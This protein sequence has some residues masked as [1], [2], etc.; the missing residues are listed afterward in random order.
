MDAWEREVVELHEVFEAYFLGTMAN[1]LSRVE[2][3][4]APEFSM[5]APSGDEV[6]RT[7]IMEYLQ[8]AYGTL[9]QF[10]IW[11]ED[12]RVQFQSDELVLASYIEAQSSSDGETRRRSSVMF[13]R[14]AGGPNGLRWLR[15][16]ETWLA[17]SEVTS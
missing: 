12:V 8:A 14:D 5:V 13:R 15:L 4:L 11:I 10:K 6:N 3:A 7:E 2:A 1:D 17:P 9:A 16:H